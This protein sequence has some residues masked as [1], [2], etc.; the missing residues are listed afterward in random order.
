[1]VEKF[2]KYEQYLI[3]R[4]SACQW[5]QEKKLERFQLVQQTPVRLIRTVRC[6][7]C[8]AQWDEIFVLDDISDFMQPTMI[9]DP[10]RQL[11]FMDRNFKRLPTDVEPTRVTSSEEP[12]LLTKKAKKDE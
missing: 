11:T 2:E 8:G 12:I 10:M 3:E 1:M 5:C 6:K 7:A 4:A 9:Y